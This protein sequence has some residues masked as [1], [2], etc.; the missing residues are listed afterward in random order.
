ML[1]AISHAAVSGSESV[2]VMGS[3]SEKSNSS[4]VTR[5]SAVDSAEVTADGDRATG[6]VTAARLAE[7]SIAYK[8]RR[9]DL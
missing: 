4:F 8:V 7:A 5:F 3:P 9:C 6:T 2:N 1:S